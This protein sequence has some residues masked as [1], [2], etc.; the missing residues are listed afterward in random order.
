M[1]IDLPAGKMV[2][3][4]SGG[5]I[6][7]VASTPTGHTRRTICEWLEGG[8]VRRGAFDRAYL[9]PSEPAQAVQ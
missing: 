8:E 1:T 7:V 3:L 2:Q 9:Q 6:M 4:K 5:P